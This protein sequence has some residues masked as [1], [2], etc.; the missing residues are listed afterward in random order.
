MKKSA[1]KVAPEIGRRREHLTLFVSDRDV[2]PTDN[3]SERALR[4]S[5]VF[6]T[7]TNGFRVG[8]SAET[9]AA[10][11]SVVST[12]KARGRAVLLAARTHHAGTQ[13]THQAKQVP[14]T[15][16]MEPMN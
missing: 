15:G 10:F 6:C 4:S 1:L 13:P 3:L 7:V 11:S 16:M 12:A 14:P 9:Y 8:L 5:V 2:P